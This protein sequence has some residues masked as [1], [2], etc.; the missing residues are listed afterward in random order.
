[1]K[2]KIILTTIFLSL[3]SA[4]AVITA[5]VDRTQVNIGQSFNLTLNVP[6]SSSRPNLQVLNKDFQIVGTS[7]SSQ[8]TII[9]GNI[10]SQ[11]NIII[12]LVPKNT[13]KLT[14]PSITV[15]NDSSKPIS[16][17]VSGSSQ[18]EVNGIANKKLILKTVL[19]KSTSYIGVPV[20]LSVKLY[21]AMNLSNLSLSP[22]QIEGADI[23]K[24][25]APIQYQSKDNGRDYQVVEQRF[26]I[27]PNRV[28]KINIP[29]IQL[30]GVA[31]NNSMLGL[32]IVT[33]QPISV[34]SNVLSLTI[35]DTP[36]NVEPS[37]WFPAKSVNVNEDWSEK[38]A[39]VNIGEPITR[40]ITINAAGIGGNSIPELNFSKVAG[41]NIY[42]DKSKPETNNQD[43]E[44]K[45]SKTFKFVYIPTQDGEVKIPE[46]TIPWWDISNNKEN[47]I[48]LSAKS[49][50][51]IGKLSTNSANKIE[52]SKAILSTNTN[53]F[54]IWKYISYG[55]SAIIVT[56]LA[57]LLVKRKRK[58][59][60]APEQFNSNTPVD[61]TETLNTNALEESIKSSSKQ[62]NQS[63][64]TACK[65]QDINAVKLA[66]YDW[67]NSKYDKKFY[68]LN[69]I[70]LHIGNSSL[71][72]ILSELEAAIYNGKSF[73]N[74][75]QLSDLISVIDNTK[76]IKVNKHELPEIYPF[77]TK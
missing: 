8:T 37:K 42:P 35:K 19:D 4:W 9:N 69:E 74:Y 7:S 52:S 21:Y 29:A 16:I 5:S 28:G 31:A 76:P 77:K 26:T 33:G 39:S 18:G 41:V 75:H 50:Q 66:I 71:K 38:S 72:E 49:Y 20:I 1:M 51:V 44:I 32:S 14:I 65:Q 3:N 23:E 30:N 55:L 60:N 62:S 57:W 73:T 46:I 6:S 15:D 48:T 67:A 12:T 25:G 11:N 22:F 70:A 61:I 2:K 45:G 56:G 40:T 53:K 47:K 17:T 64:S 34:T 13:G 10:N 54:D 58:S 24:S 36:D 59:I 27:T 68:S 63:L 43:G